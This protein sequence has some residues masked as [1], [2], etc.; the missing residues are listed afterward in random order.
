MSSR[1]IRSI[2]A[3]ATLTA[4]VS[5][6]AAGQASADQCADMVS[7][8]RAPTVAQ[9]CDEL[10]DLRAS[11]TYGGRMTA[12]RDSELATE[13]ESLSRRLG[14]SGLS[15]SSA[16]LSFADL[17]GVAA[18]AGMP[19]LPSGMPG[20]GGLPTMTRMATTP[21][22]PGL[23]NLPVLP[24][25]RNLAAVE[26]VPALPDASGLTSVKAPLNL[27]RRVTKI[28]KQ[29]TLPETPAVL[30]DSGAGG[31]RLPDGDAVTERVDG[32][33]KGLNLG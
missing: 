6:L 22:L 25:A 28:R 8:L 21:D 27:P 15:K 18:A 33:L 1:S 24:G 17:G 30:Q 13:V 32:L 4:G 26:K 3:V 23:P 7:V 10:T 31:L 2:L 12:R 5:W 11:G 9:V 16:V 20:K 14:M 19:S 29:V